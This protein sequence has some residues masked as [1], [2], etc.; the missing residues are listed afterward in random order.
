MKEATSE[1]STTMIA[2][3]AIAAV[4][5]IFT[6]LLLPNLKKSI[7]AR[8]HCADAVCPNECTDGEVQ[9]VWYDYED[10]GTQGASHD[11][12]CTCNE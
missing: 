3:V 6:V 5:T 2:I 7:N 1:L 10:D 4:L 9:C 12:T 11:I 8:M